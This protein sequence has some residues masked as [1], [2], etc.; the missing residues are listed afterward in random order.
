MPDTS[1]GVFLADRIPANMFSDFDVFLCI[2]V[3][4]IHIFGGRE[5]SSRMLLFEYVHSAEHRHPNEYGTGEENSIGVV[6]GK[7]FPR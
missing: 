3:A 2:L 7:V 1:D 6:G 5:Q 4:Q